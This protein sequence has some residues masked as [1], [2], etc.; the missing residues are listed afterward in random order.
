MI[1]QD[2]RIRVITGHYG[3]G[4]TE[5][6][7]NYAVALGQA[8]RKAALCD[9]D[10]VNPYFRSRQQ[11]TMLRE[12]GVEVIYSSLRGSNI[13]IPAVSAKITGPMVDS[14]YDYVIDLGGNDVGVTALNRFQPFI[15]WEEA[16]LFLTVN[17]FR[18][19]TSTPEGV[20]AQMAAIERAS[21]AKITGLINNSNLVRETTWACLE[22]GDRVLRQV[23][24]ETGVPV[25]YVSYVKELCLE[26]DVKA[27]SAHVCGE[28][29]PMTYFMREAWM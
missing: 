5:F 15:K 7:V 12:T 21:G 1:E 11:E 19:D 4:K 22:E 16:E 18:P 10:I 29:F 13:D 14:S 26:E 23:T 20:M 2:K 25:R 28:L 9:L 8:G 27:G 24:K 17:V 6:A 3:S